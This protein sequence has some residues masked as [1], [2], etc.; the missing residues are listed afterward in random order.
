MC[1]D[2]FSVHSFV[3]SLIRKQ[4]I[5]KILKGKL[6]DMETEERKKKKKK[7]KMSGKEKWEKIQRTEIQKKEKK[8]KQSG[9]VHA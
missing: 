8:T 1:L 6:F 2:I 7:T 4:R 3:R 9:M 5:R